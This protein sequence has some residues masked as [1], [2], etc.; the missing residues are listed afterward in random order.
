[1]AAFKEQ[2]DTAI[3][4]QVFI[5][6]FKSSEVKRY[7]KFLAQ[8]DKSLRLQ[9]TK[10]ELTEFSRRKLE[11]ELVLVDQVLDGIYQKWGTEFRKEITKFSGMEAAFEAKTLE[12]VA[13]EGFSFSIPSPTQL[14]SAVFTNPLSVRGSYQGKLLD[15]FLTDFTKG[16]KDLLS[17]AIRQGYF[18][19]KTNFEILKIIRGTKAAK[20]ADGL[21]NVSKNNAT[22]IVRTAVQHVSSMARL[23]TWNENDDIIEGYQWVSALDTRTTAQCR[24]L[25][26]M[27]F[28]LGKGPVPPIHV[29]CR[30]TTIAEFKDDLKFLQEGRTR[31]SILGKVEDQTYYDWLKKQSP[32]FQDTAIGKERGRLLRLGG[33]SSEEFARL[34]LGRDFQPLT[35]DEMREK[36]PVAFVKAFGK[37]GK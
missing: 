24:S 6:R 14:K 32:E 17:G 19:G 13:P 21:L 11:A 29:S 15:P 25:D 4:R 35:L 28:K 5:E 27:I 9:L 22:A 26:G 16:Q 3:R 33:L 7:E 30:S 37:A 34:N 31:A 8:I 36:D 12:N 18:E 1:M 10:S 20:Y 2:Q 23:E